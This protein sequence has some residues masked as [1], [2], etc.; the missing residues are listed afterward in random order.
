MGKIK[1]GITGQSGFIGTHLYNNLNLLK[2]RFELIPFEDS[3]FENKDKLKA[4]LIQ[5]DTV[6]HL[7]AV[8]RHNESD[9]IY[10]TN[11]ELIKKLIQSLEE[12]NHYPQ[13]IFASS[14]QEDNETP[15]GESKKQGR[16]LLE[17]WAKKNNANLLSLIIPNVFGPF[18]KPFFNSVISTFS[19]QLTHNL[20]PHIEVDSKLKLIYVQEL[21]DIM[22]SKIQDKSNEKVYK[23]PHSAEMYVTEILEI[24]KSYKLNY[25]E[26]KIFPYFNFEIETALFNTFRSYIDI[27]EFFPQYLK[28]NTDDRGEFV[29]ILKA[30]GENQ[31]S[32]STTKP[33]VVR[34]NHFHRRK[35]ERFIVIKGKADINLRK[36]G[37]DEILTFHLDGKNPAFVD[38]PIWYTHNII[39]TGNDELY[40]IFWINEFYNPDNPDTFFEKV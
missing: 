5:C 12:E 27:K 2:D 11:L 23:V 8:N 33:G 26:N 34:G 18:G 25:L 35:I 14:S 28:I 7:A 38:M 3:Y 15:Y 39:N 36:I 1:V 20:E 40:T 32:Y 30:K 4:F 37:S 22:I 24:L 21:V 31:I 17:N 19:Y 6:V 10:N 9:Y 29:E 13:I 16:I